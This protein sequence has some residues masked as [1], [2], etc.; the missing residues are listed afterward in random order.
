M[1]ILPAYAKLNLA[2]EVTGRHSSGLHTLE[3]VIVRI[4]WHDLVGVGMSRDAVT[5]SLVI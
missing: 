2:L 5:R 1:I 4:D 3:S